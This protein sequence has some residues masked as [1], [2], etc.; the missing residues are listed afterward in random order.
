MGFLRQF[1]V[2]AGEKILD[3]FRPSE[4][5]MLAMPGVSVLEC[6]PYRQI[7]IVIHGFLPEASS[8]RFYPYCPEQFAHP[9]ALARGCV[10]L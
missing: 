3:F 5:K 1:P 10:V 9:R 4:I 2:T 6:H 7:P 8:L